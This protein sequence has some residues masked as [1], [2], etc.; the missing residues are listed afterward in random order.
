MVVGYRIATDRV[1]T[2]HQQLIRDYIDWH[3]PWLLLLQ[4][5]SKRE[6]IK[7]ETLS[8][9]H[10]LTVSN[11]FRLYPEIIDPGFVRA[12]RVESALRKSD[13]DNFDEE[14]FLA[15]FYLELNDP[16]TN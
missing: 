6:R 12:A 14:K 9:Q 7:Y 8:R 3:A 5:L 16:H 4:N 11:Q 13:T 10:A 1:D 15:T 2:Q